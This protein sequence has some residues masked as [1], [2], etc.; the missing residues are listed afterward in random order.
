MLINKIS[1]F[2]FLSIFFT[3]YTQNLTQQAKKITIKNEKNEKIEIHYLNEKGL[4][5][6][7]GYNE[8]C[9]A[10]SVGKTKQIDIRLFDMLTELQR[11]AEQNNVKL[12]I[13]PYKTPKKAILDG[14]TVDDEIKVRAFKYDKGEAIAFYVEGVD[15]IALSE[16]LKGY[17][18]LVAYGGIG[19]NLEGEKNWIHFDTGEPLVWVGY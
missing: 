15:I 4:L 7:K 6:V 19:F 8:L 3:G 11:N 5:L 2:L 10:F 17:Q 16:W 9:R 18:S 14:I 1:V 12:V 13:T